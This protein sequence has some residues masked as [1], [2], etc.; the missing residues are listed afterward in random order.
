M[1][2]Q[3]EEKTAQEK[4]PMRLDKYLKVSR[5]IKRRTVANEACDM[6]RVMVNG[7]EAKAGTTVKVGDVITLRAGDKKTSYQV[8]SLSEHVLKA[9]AAG[10]YKIPAGASGLC[11]T[12]AA[13][14]T[15]ICMFSPSSTSGR[16][17]D[18]WPV[19]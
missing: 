17:K 11:S 3:R 7:K 5:I 2:Q 8:V 12:K 16:R 9:D 1:R 10:M 18:L 15:S 14:Y 19:L 6:G 4:G 13:R